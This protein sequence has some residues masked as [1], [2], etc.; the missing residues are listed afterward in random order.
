M[1]ELMLTSGGKRPPALLDEQSPLAARSARS[2][3]CAAQSTNCCFLPWKG[4]Y[5]TREWSPHRARSAQRHRSLLCSVRYNRGCISSTTLCKDPIPARAERSPT[6]PRTAA[7]WY[8]APGACRRG[9]AQGAAL[10]APQSHTGAGTAPPHALLQ[11][12]QPKAL[13][14]PR[15]GG[16]DGQSQEGLQGQHCEQCARGAHRLSFVPRS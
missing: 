12:R 9:A 10:G 16:D 6:S 2:A 3:R 4:E 5:P 8:R 11:G 1:V 13:T 15:Q 7:C 14:I